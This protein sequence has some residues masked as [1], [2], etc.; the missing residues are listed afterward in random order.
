MFNNQ[1]KGGQE[2]YNPGA[3]AYQAQLKNIN[4][5]TSEIYFP[6]FILQVRYDVFPLRNRAS[7]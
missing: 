6:I 3:P 4:F 7:Q 5:D 1:A 2:V